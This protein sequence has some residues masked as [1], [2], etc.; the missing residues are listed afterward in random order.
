MA[1]AV[2]FY[3]AGGPE[4]LRIEEVDVGAP[5]PGEVRIRHAAVGLNFADTYFRMGYYPVPLPN[6]MG[7]EAAGVVEAIG[8]GV[9]A[10]APGDRVTYT[11]SPLGAYSSER[12]MPAAPL[13]KLP[14]G[15]SFE[16][17]AASTMRGLTAAYWLL[18][19]NPWLKA[20]DT[21]L[22]HAAA[23]GV[24]LLAVQWAKLLGLR[25]IGTVSTEEKAAKARSYGCD[26]I[27]FYRRED[28]P[29]RV[30]EL[31][32]GQG[33]STVFDSVGKDTFEGSLKSLK[34]R[35]VLVGCGTASGPFPPIDAM[36]M[37]VQG[38]VYFTRPALADY[39]SDPAERAELSGLWFDHLAAGRIKVDIGQRYALE[40]CVQAH[41]DLEAGTSIGS[42]V[43]LL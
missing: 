31:T 15:V 8:E 42:S 22:I 1:K 39:Y 43:F 26:E 29:A 37:V 30:K 13:F 40:E 9:V 20:G 11:G 3:E 33:V 18:R 4:V 21:V 7:V 38:S 10:F 41:R 12:V 27:I 36:Q 2:R 6:G 14:G 25:V 32:G 17:A 5:G 24:G 23:G 35:G 16:T 34:R 19:T 28:V